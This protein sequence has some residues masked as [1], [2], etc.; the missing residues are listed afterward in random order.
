MSG[1]STHILD[2]TRGQPA[3]GV[4][5]RLSREVDG[6]WTEISKRTTDADGRVKSMLR[7]NEMLESGRY[8][9]H[10]AT[11]EYFGGRGVEAFHPFVE[12]AFEVRHAD[13]HYHVPL[14]LTPYGYSTY[15]GS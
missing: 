11:A 15:R 8:R 10:F 9:L 13:E 5:V 14:L 12:I 1:I 2:L 6:G 3:S 7:E 4:A